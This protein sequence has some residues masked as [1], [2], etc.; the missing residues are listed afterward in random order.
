MQT[1]EA[2]IQ[3]T[4]ADAPSWGR[5]LALAQMYFYASN[6]WGMPC[7]LGRSQLNQR[8]QVQHKGYTYI[9]IHKQQQVQPNGCVADGLQYDLDVI[10]LRYC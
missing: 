8:M 3:D 2:R 1:T 10:F 7:T 4:R 9:V 5:A 6:H